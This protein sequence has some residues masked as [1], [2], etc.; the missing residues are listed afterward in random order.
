MGPDLDVIQP[1]AN[2]PGGIG[3][4]GHD[5]LYVQP[6]GSLGMGYSRGPPC[7]SD[8]VPMT[9]PLSQL[10]AEGL[11]IDPQR[12]TEQTSPENTPEWDSLAAMTM[13]SLVEDTFAV[14]LTTRDIMKMR[15]VALAREVLRAKGVSGI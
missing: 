12:V 3:E 6:L 14:R 11:G 1:P 10:F 5:A 2:P 13:V 9:D 7:P 4:L 15:T 8:G